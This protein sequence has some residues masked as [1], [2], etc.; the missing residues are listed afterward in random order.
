[1]KL[2]VKIC[3][4]IPLFLF[5]MSNRKA[6][7]DFI[8]RYID[9]ILPGSDNVKIYKDLF[10]KMNDE[11]FDV[12]MKKLE[13]GENR[14]AIIAPN[15]GQQK[16]DVQRNLGIGKELNHK[17]FQ[18]ILIQGSGERPTYKTPIPYMVVDLPLRRQ[19]QLLV[20]KIS[21]PEDNRTVDQLTGQPTGS[22]K[23]SKISYP[24][25][26]VLAAMSLDNS[27][28]ELLKFRG[29]D[30]KGF[31]AM[32]KMISTTGG[33]SLDTIERFAGGVEST[34]TLKAYLTSMHLS[35]TL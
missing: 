28:L 32:N 22:S 19:A 33:V 9:K 7:E 27:L 24:E 31:N 12:F 1:M 14:L 2:S 16:L 23:G 13:N 26:Q 8:I 15:F 35:N 3:L 21:I 4:V 17:W 5:N 34:K 6:A 29:G 18:Q 25:I 20:K 30:I 10:G 11:D